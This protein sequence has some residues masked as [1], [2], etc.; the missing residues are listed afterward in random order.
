MKIKQVA[1]IKY[2]KRKN[3][4]FF[5]QFLVEMYDIGEWKAECCLWNKNS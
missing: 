4:V 5:E 1:V 3:K 2:G